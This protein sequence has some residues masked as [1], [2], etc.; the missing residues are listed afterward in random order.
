MLSQI[1]MLLLEVDELYK[2]TS[3]RKNKIFSAY[4]NFFRE[5]SKSEKYKSISDAPVGIVEELFEELKENMRKNDIVLI[6][7][8][9]KFEI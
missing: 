8:D 9:W 7:Q 1:A 3:D 6:V 2:R 5:F 4:T